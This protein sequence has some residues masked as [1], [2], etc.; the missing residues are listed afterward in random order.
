MTDKTKRNIILILLIVAII[1][2]ILIINYV[3][4]NSN[5]S[6]ETLKCIAENS[7]LYVSKTCSH[8]AEQKAI[9]GD[10]LNYFNMTDCAENAQKCADDGVA[11]VPT[12][13]IGNQT[14]SGVKS[15]DELKILTGC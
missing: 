4:G 2:V 9:L 8:C 11:V 13:I 10:G 6:D 14:Y 12:W 1:L 7:K 3:K 5:G 15:I